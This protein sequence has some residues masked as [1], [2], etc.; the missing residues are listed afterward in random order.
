M[1]TTYLIIQ[2]GEQCSSTINP[3]ALWHVRRNQNRTNEDRR[4]T[5]CTQHAAAI[6]RLV[7]RRLVLFKLVNRRHRRG[8]AHHRCSDT[9]RHAP[10]RKIGFR[11]RPNISFVRPFGKDCVCGSDTPNRVAV[12]SS[13]TE[14]VW[15]IT[16][17]AGYRR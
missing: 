11:P 8:C 10:S 13:P 4:V 1:Y 2:A 3:V 7:K 6:A 15:T 14:P 17:N 9:R 12:L 16:S 5:R